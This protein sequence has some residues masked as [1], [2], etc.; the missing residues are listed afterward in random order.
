MAAKDQSKVDLKRDLQPATDLDMG[1]STKYG[2]SA[3]ALLIDLLVSILMAAL[4]YLLS[5]GLLGAIIVFVIFMLILLAMSIRVIT[6]WNRM[7]VLRFGRYKGM[8][9]PGFV[10]ILPIIERTPVS[11]DLRVISTT[12]NAEQT[13]TEDNVPVDVDAILFWQV[14]NPER[15][16][17]NVQSYISSI[18]LA[19]QT[20]LR[21]V[22]GKSELSEMLAGRDIIGKDIDLLIQNRISSWGIRAISVEIRDVKIPQAL[23]DAM[24]RVATSEREKSARVILAESESL[25]ADKMLEASA[26]YRKDAYAMQLRALNMMYEISLNG[27]NLMIF[28]PTESRGYSMPTPV[29]I[30]GVDDLIKKVRSSSQL[31]QKQ[32]K[33]EDAE[34]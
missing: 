9:G 15:C 31:P 8:I 32:K 2:G 5:G 17:L 10:T 23:Q 12:F 28:I 22:I 20:A 26:K 1:V 3:A 30:V 33:Q 18:Q 6:E 13:L 14:T 27:K 4:A 11:V 25:A 7:P 16:I 19:S 24:A 34:A 29:G 21:D